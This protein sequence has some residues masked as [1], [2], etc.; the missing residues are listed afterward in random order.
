MAK[1]PVNELD[2][3]IGQR[4]RKLRRRY[5][6]SAE[7]LADALGTTQQQISRYENGNNK[8]GAAQ[9]YYLAHYL[10]VPVSWF[11]YGYSP[12][13]PPPAMLAEPEPVYLASNQ[14][15]ELRLL[16][17]SWPQLSASERELILKMLDTFI[18]KHQ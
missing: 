7:K 9:L 1:P 18:L 4:L 12:E 17:Q 8:L 5:S 15:D 11:Y 13:R 16:Q 10:N 3:H 2:R 14:G 6:I